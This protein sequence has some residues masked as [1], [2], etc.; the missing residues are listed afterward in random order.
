MNRVHGLGLFAENK[1]FT[2]WPLIKKRSYTRTLKK[3]LNRFQLLEWYINQLLFS[4]NTWFI[5]E[6]PR[7]YSP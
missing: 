2:T 7:K 5:E 3:L 1:H 4:G 6:M